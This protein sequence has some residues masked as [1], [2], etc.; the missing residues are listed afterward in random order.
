MKG[1]FL[2][3]SLE[4]ISGGSGRQMGWIRAANTA[5][6]MSDVTVLNNSQYIHKEA[7]CAACCVPLLVTG[8][9]QCCVKCSVAPLFIATLIS[10]RYCS[11]ECHQAMYLYREIQRWRHQ[12]LPILICK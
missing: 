11:A 6:K 4:R 1:K 8:I 12:R 2:T 10:Q 7:G 3:K 5:G 9:M